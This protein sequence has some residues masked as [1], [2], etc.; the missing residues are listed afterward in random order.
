MDL[1]N[2]D[3]E[4]QQ[5]M[6]ENIKAYM[7]LHGLKNYEEFANKVGASKMYIYNVINFK[8]SPSMNYMDK[9]AKE[10]G[11]TST[12]LITKGF[13]DQFETKIVKKKT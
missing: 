2:I 1:L 10:M 9:F 13:F 11:I 4:S 12:E 6:V 7:K 3:L 8:S 5:N